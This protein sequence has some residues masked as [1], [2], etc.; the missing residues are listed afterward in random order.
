MGMAYHGIAFSMATAYALYQK[1]GLTVNYCF[2]RKV[3]D[4]RGRELCGYTLKDGDK[5]VIID[6]LICSGQTLSERMEHILKLA[7]IEIA[8]VVVIADR[9]ICKDNQFD[10]GSKMIEKKYKT[11]VYSII[12]ED[13]IKSALQH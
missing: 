4:S 9:M 11:K 6:D 8:A 2:D 12:T 1:Y 13:D 10:I 7:N 5:V 3:A